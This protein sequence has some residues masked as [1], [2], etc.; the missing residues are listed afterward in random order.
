M[1]RAP[2][3]PSQQQ[4]FAAVALIF[5]LR[6][7]L[8]TETMPYYLLP[9]VRHAARL[10]RR[11]RASVLLRGLAG[12]A[13]AYALFDRLTP[14]VVRFAAASALYDVVTIAAA[15]RVRGLS[16]R[17]SRPMGG[18]ANG[19]MAAAAPAPAARDVIATITRR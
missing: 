19:G 12:T 14:P 17:E 11:S 15:L 3:R 18:D 6:C 13:V 1:A 9:P 10:G 16:R 8:D 4:L 2:R 5:V 7:T